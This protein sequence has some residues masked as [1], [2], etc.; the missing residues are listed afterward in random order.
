MLRR[1]S[2]TLT[3]ALAALLLWAAGCAVE[4]HPAA[5]RPAAEGKPAKPPFVDVAASMGVDFVTNL[6]ETRPRDILQTNGSGCAL[7]DY[8]GDGLLDLLLLGNPRCALY[9]NEGARFRDVTAGSGLEAEGYWIGA[10]AADWDNDGD[11]DILLTGYECGALLR[12]DAGRF[13]NVTAGSSL[14]F[15]RWGQSAAWF[16]W[17]RDGLLD[18]YISGYAR[19]GKDSV[20]FC[21]RGETQVVCGPEMYDPEPGRL[22]LAVAPG[23]FREMSGPILD[24]RGHGR[25]WGV[26][27]QDVDDD[28]WP[29][30]Y[31]ANDMIACDLMINPGGG[32]PANRAT[33]FGVAYDGS[34]RPIGAMAADWADYDGDEMPD[35]LVTNFENDPTL[36]LTN[37]GN[38]SFLD[39]SYAVGVGEPT[40]RY[41]GF[42]GR[43]LDFDND[44]WRDLLLANGHVSDNAEAITSSSRYRQPVQ[45]LRNLGGRFIEMSRELAALPAIVARGAAFGDWDNDGRIDAVVANLEGPPLLLRNQTRGGNWLGIKLAGSRGNRDGIGARVWVK[46]ASLPHRQRLECQ[47]AA[48][49]LSSNDPR[50][51]FG[52]GPDELA[53]VEIRWPSGAVTT[54]RDLP[55]NQYHTIVEPGD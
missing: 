9:R 26:A 50:L 27:P 30:L 13:T 1:S 54:L 7:L 46:H 43:W 24:V 39:E 8:D 11:T 40:A 19:F 5:P 31:L 44:G 17:N 3:A 34:G 25:T 12:N 48:S 35:L 15:P 10:A 52:L 49:L 23:K 20:R 55:A 14:I 51:L 16:D 2:L 4:A 53:D 37:L 29:D 18:L 28:G 42:G 21:T 47:T 22:F 6:V 36:I 45:L 33:K 41:V 38:G 32:R